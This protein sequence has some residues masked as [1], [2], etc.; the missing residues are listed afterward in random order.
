MENPYTHAAGPA[1]EAA[2]ASAEEQRSADYQVAIGPNSGYYL[3]R[4]EEFDRGGSAVG[5]HWP[6]F[7]VTTPWFLYRKMYLPGILNIVYPFA[8]LILCSIASAFLIKPIQAHPGLF[9]L[10]FL[11]LL[12]APWFLLPM[13]ANALYHRHIGKVIDGIPRSVA[14]IPE[15]RV[16]RL[17]RDGGT[18]VGVMIGVCAGLGFFFIFIVG[19]LAAIAIP[20][21]QDYT[22]RAQVTEGLN[23]AQVPKMAVANSWADTGV[24]PADS[25]AAGLD[26]NPSGKFVASVGVVDGSI[27]ITYGNA[28]HASLH[29]KR[30]ALL[31][32]VGAK[33]D[34]Y[35]KCGNGSH[36]AGVKPADGPSGSD[37]ANKYMP[38]ACREGGIAPRP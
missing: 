23:L 16:A 32:G 13:Y 18:G 24:W 38:S 12:A 20:A 34:I 31:P 26:R 6:A 1:A 27:I 36:P 3:P 17:E 35:W 10:V 15:K 14:Q 29:G 8:L 28:A 4:F 11:A 33:G 21:Y 19:V 25:A 9:G 22:I 37:L 30:L 2:P 5:W 7:F